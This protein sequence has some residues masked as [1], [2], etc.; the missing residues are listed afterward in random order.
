MHAGISQLKLAVFGSHSHLHISINPDERTP[1]RA[2]RE[3]PLAK[4]IGRLLAGH[5]EAKV[6]NA[7]KGPAEAASRSIL[8]SRRPVMNYYIHFLSI[9]S[10]PERICTC[11]H[12]SQAV[13]TVR[14]SQPLM[15]FPCSSHCYN[16][17]RSRFPRCRNFRH[18]EAGL[19]PDLLDE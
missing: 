14:G 5:N 11:V 12:N 13:I 10:H 18:S 7:A 3:G 15:H 8:Q 4:A 2:S 17:H 19:S 16:I 6:P 1:I 9:Q